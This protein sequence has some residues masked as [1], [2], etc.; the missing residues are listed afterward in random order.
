MGTKSCE[1]VLPISGDS[2]ERMND[3][4]VDSRSCF[5]F[6][7]YLY[8]CNK[9]G[10][11]FLQRCCHVTDVLHLIKPSVRHDERRGLPTL[12]A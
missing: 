9:A 2:V 4:L 3:A 5:S 7:S 1:K 8:E 11:P 10:V 12:N 6:L